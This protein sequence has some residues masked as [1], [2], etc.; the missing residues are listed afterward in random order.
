MAALSAGSRQ[1]VDWQRSGRGWLGNHSVV[2]CGRQG[3]QRLS[4]HRRR[5]VTK[6]HQGKQHQKSNKVEQLIAL[7]QAEQSGK[8]WWKG[9]GFYAAVDEIIRDRCGDCSGASEAGSHVH[10]RETHIHT[11][12]CSFPSLVSLPCEEMRESCA[13]GIRVWSSQGCQMRNP[14]FHRVSQLHSCITCQTDTQTV[15]K[16]PYLRFF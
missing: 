3:K 4:R 2:W 9:Q 8:E 10:T 1:G 6:S 7:W 11:C 16:T 12:V 5:L 13:E 14:W 15:H